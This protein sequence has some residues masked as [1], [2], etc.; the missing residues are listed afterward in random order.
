MVCS[1]AFWLI[2]ALVSWL[3]FAVAWAL[4][5]RQTTRRQRIDTVVSGKRIMR[6]PS[7]DGGSISSYVLLFA[8]AAQKSQ[9][10]AVSKRLWNTTRAGDPLV[11]FRIEGRRAGYAHPS[12]PF[13]TASL[14]TLLLLGV[15]GMGGLFLP[16]AA[17]MSFSGTPFPGCV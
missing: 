6:A 12:R 5:K 17:A 1:S 3:V 16:I 8:D 9:W 2:T 10:V 11:V 14:P 4:A 13:R 7:G 15:S